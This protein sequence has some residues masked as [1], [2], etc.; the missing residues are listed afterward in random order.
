MQVYFDSIDADT[1][2]D[3]TLSVVQNCTDASE[4]LN[5]VEVKLSMSAIRANSD[6]LSRQ[7]V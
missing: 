4:T 1:E 2:F 3:N 5:G 7:P 6:L